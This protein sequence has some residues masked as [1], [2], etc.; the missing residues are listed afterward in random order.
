MSFRVEEKNHSF[1]MQDSQNGAQFCLLARLS[2]DLSDGVF[3]LDWKGYHIPV[4]VEYD[5]RKGAPRTIVTIES[6]GKVP[7]FPSI[8]RQYPD[9][10]DVTFAPGDRERCELIV[11]EALV[12]YGVHYDGQKHPDGTFTVHIEHGP[13]AG[14]YTLSSFGYR[15]AAYSG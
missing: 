7:N 8:H 12:V 2:R 1:S 14:D 10:S 13:N 3:L 6:L 9:L 15:G 4:V 5:D 11:A